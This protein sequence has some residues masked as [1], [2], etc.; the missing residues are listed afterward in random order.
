MLILTRVCAEFHNRSGQTVLTVRPGQ[1][2]S[3][4]EAPEEIQEDPLF[5][6]ML[7]D[8]SLEAVRS[9]SD[10]RKLESDPLA[11]ITPEGKKANR[12]RAKAAVSEAKETAPIGTA[13]D[14]GQES[15]NTEEP[16][17]SSEA[18]AANVAENSQHDV[19]SEIPEGESAPAKTGRKSQK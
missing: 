3:F 1:L 8:G 18:S 12:S 17:S 15:G 14:P 9:V 2:L 4:L 6:M 11:G 19:L 13:A 5:S 7:N 10:Q 16:D